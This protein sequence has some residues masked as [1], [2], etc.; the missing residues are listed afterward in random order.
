MPALP[1]GHPAVVQAL[2]SPEEAGR[3]DGKARALNIAEVDEAI[4]K[5]HPELDYERIGFRTRAFIA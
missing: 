1:Q 2:A 4:R 3:L 5:G